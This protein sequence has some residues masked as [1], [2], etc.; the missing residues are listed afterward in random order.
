[1][2][3]DIRIDLGI[4]PEQKSL[5]I[6]DGMQFIIPEQDYNL[7]LPDQDLSQLYQFGTMYSVQEDELIFYLVGFADDVTVL[8]AKLVE[9]SYAEQYDI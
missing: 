9:S 4:H 7:E 6:L 2:I 3:R 8:L 5:I 1:M